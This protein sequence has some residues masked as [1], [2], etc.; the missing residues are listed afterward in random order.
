[1]AT[2]RISHNTTQISSTHEATSTGPRPTK[3]SQESKA[4][5]PSRGVQR[6]F[7]QAEPQISELAL[8]IRDRMVE[9]LRTPREIEAE[10]DLAKL[11]EAVR[12][13][14]Q[15]NA[16]SAEDSSNEDR[17]LFNI[18]T[19]G[20]T[21][22]FKVVETLV[23]GLNQIKNEEDDLFD[24]ESIEDAAKTLFLNSPEH[25]SGTPGQLL[26]QSISDIANKRKTIT[27]KVEERLPLFQALDK[28]L[29]AIQKA[30]TEKS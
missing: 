20:D 15:I 30:V 2:K 13:F 29:Q 17:A 11:N 22:Q 8:K 7:H 10:F 1:M 18:S 24:P 23:N 4:G 5:K 9:G 14:P 21:P 27:F 12:I 19:N 16:N 25:P 28:F 3:A 6:K 26:V